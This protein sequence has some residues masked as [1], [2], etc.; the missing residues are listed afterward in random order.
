[1]AEQRMQG[2]GDLVGTEKVVEMKAS[3]NLEPLQG[4]KDRNAIVLG[5]ISPPRYTRV[6]NHQG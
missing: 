4:K 6:L 1:M 5:E 2:G 3:L